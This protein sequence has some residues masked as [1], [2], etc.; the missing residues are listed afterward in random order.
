MHFVRIMADDE[1]NAEE[2]WDALRE[3]LPAVAEG[4]TRG[5]V[6]VALDTWA[7]IQGLP[8]FAGGPDHAGTAVVVLGY[9]NAR[10]GSA[11]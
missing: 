6:E 5:S 1:Y 10:W 4:L 11:L 2:F 3:S 8:G 7:E 9:R